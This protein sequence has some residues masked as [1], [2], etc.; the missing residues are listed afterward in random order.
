MRELFVYYRVR[1]ADAGAAAGA[2]RTMQAQLRER[3]PPLR[4]RLMRRPEQADGL[5]TW[6]EIYATDPLQD[7]AGVSAALQAEIEAHANG[8]SRFVQ[9]ARHTE[10]FIEVAQ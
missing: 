9:G 8:L 3:H 2:V 7:S 10:V 1:T 4:T 6:M 5:Q